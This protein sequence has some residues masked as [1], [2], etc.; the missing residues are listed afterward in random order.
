[1]A[2]VKAFKI[3]VSVVVFFSFVY[4]GLDPEF[5]CKFAS[6][7]SNTCDY[8]ERILLLNFISSAWAFILT[9]ALAG[10][11]LHWVRKD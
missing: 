10:M 9:V 4:W 7:L 6:D 8:S 1:M 3:I 2:K 5:I 11:L